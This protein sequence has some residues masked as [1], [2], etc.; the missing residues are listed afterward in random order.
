MAEPLGG[1]TDGFMQ[2]EFLT[3]A[4]VVQKQNAKRTTGARTR[5]IMI[6]SLPISDFRRFIFPKP[7]VNRSLPIDGHPSRLRR[8]SKG[9]IL[10][11]LRARD[12]ARIRSTCRPARY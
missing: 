7:A 1:F 11:P 9:R 6:A 5:L 10:V 12:I 8:S 4:A 3:C 2:G